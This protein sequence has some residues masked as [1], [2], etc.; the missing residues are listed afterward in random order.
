MSYDEEGVAAFFDELNS[1]GHAVK[2]NRLMTYR[3]KFDRQSLFSTILDMID[4]TL[5]E[6]A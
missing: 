5:K 6:H 3:Q 4:P 2:L 1:D